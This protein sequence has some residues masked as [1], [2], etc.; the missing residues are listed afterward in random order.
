MV[1]LHEIRAIALALPQVD[2]GPPVRAARRIAAFKVAGKSFVGLEKGGKTM[3]IS[4]G[5]IEAKHFMEDQPEA[6]EAIWR[7][8]T[9][10]MGLRVDLSQVTVTQ[11][12][13]LIK[14][15]WFHCA[16]KKL[17]EDWQRQE[18]R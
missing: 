4:L 17:V 18:N 15:S 11:V 14:K 7:N 3:T 10:F 13:E 5:E 1:E 9:K 2:E 6:Y 8:S 12:R 16:P